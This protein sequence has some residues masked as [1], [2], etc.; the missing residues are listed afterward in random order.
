MCILCFMTACSSKEDVVLNGSDNSYHIPESLLSEGASRIYPGYLSGDFEQGASASPIA[1]RVSPELLSLDRRITDPLSV[2]IFHDKDYT[3]EVGLQYFAQGLLKDSVAIETSDDDGYR[4]Y[5]SSLGSRRIDYVTSFD[6]ESLLASG[7][8]PAS[9][10]FLVSVITQKTDR[11]QSDLL[12]TKATCTIYVML[13]S[14]S[15][16]IS[17][18]GT[19]CSMVYAQPIVSGVQQL[20]ND[21]QQ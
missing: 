1:L 14:F 10:D 5:R 4:Y 13:D 20:L 6:Y 2:L 21:W 9:S 11:N 7:A 16:H 8:R 3:K 15:V 12:K 19:V 18:V 17:G